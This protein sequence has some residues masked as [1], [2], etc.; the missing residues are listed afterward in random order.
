MD[1]RPLPTSQRAEL[2]LLLALLSG[3]GQTEHRAGTP[4]AKALAERQSSRPV[5]VIV[6]RHNYYYSER[7]AEVVRDMV[8]VN[9][10][11]KSLVCAVSPG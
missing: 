4:G 2:G 11:K 6:N 9:G 7:W 5:S 1:S 3:S 10:M 8:G